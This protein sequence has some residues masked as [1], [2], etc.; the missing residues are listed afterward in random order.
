MP[1]RRPV[2]NGNINDLSY[3]CCQITISIVIELSFAT[4]GGFISAISDTEE[5]GYYIPLGF[6][7]GLFIGHITASTLFLFGKLKLEN[8]RFEI[9]EVS[10]VVTESIHFD[11]VDDD[12]NF[13]AFI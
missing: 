12:I 8:W 4:L 5:T 13:T 6:A 9:V 1:L 3:I 7:I 10:R 2:P 11:D